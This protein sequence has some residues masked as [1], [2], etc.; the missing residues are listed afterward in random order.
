MVLHTDCKSVDLGF[1][2]LLALCINKRIG[3][4]QNV[5]GRYRLPET[6]LG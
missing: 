6:H 5:N 3:I 2:P 1:D 4:S